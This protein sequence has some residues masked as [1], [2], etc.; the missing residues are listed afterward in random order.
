MRIVLTG[1]PGAGKTAILE[2]LKANFDGNLILIPEAASII[3]S[4][5]FWRHNSLYAKKA[6]Q[7]AIFH[8]QKEMEYMVEM[9]NKNTPAICDRGTLDGL[10]Y[11]PE[12][13]KIFWQEVKTNREAELKRYDLVIHL[14]TPNERQGY[15]HQNPLRIESSLEAHQIDQRIIAAWEGH[16]NRIFIQ[17]YPDFIQKS[18]EAIKIIQGYLS[19]VRSV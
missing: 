2:L 3:F 5:G 13:E 18:N 8:I 12:D 17:N 9:E 4:G 7:R 16:P 10:A 1:G 11:W 15:N 19:K 6:S 14:R